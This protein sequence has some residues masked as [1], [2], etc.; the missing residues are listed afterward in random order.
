MEFV[1]VQTYLG[2]ILHIVGIALLVPVVVILLI[3]IGYAIFSIGSILV[4]YFTERKTFKAEMPEFLAALMEAEQEDIPRVIWESGLLARQKAALLTVF[5]YRALPGES[6]VALMK[7]LISEQES[8]FARRTSRNSTVAKVAPMVGLMGT[9]IPLGPGIAALGQGD[10]V[11][12]SSSIVIAFDT[13]VAGLASAGVCIVISRIRRNWYE[14]Y[15]AATENSMATLHE[16][17]SSMREE[18][19]IT[20]TKPSSYA[21]LFRS[22]LRGKD[23]QAV[24][25]PVVVPEDA[26]GRTPTP[27]DLDAARAVLAGEPV[28]LNEVPEAAVAQDAPEIL[29]APPETAGAAV[30]GAAGE[31]VGAANGGE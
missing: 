9:L 2:D 26:A 4:E 31:A 17:I 11:S 15:M 13:T 12:L 29:D 7:Q 27:E 22:S 24:P 6:L 1:T 28:G 10:I 23:L 3:L 20:E 25:M 8:R 14:E 5:D 21:F 30:D 18:G 16:K 19:L